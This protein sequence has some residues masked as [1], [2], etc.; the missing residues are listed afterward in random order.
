MAAR[1]SG[2][3]EAPCSHYI[4]LSLTWLYMSGSM[5]SNGIAE[6]NF[7]TFQLLYKPII[8]I[9]LL[10]SFGNGFG[11]LAT[12]GL[13]PNPCPLEVRDILCPSAWPPLL[14]F[15]E[16]K[17]KVAFL[18]SCQ[19]SLSVLLDSVIGFS[20]GKSHSS[21]FTWWIIWLCGCCLFKKYFN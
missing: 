1:A 7:W 14:P 3:T 4:M 16:A 15:R 17:D 11:S 20:F 6:T 19:L 13:L 8:Y 2:M 9:F 12:K 10:K 5:A 18:T 21:Y